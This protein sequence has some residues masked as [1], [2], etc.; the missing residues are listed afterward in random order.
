M[1]WVCLYIS[2]TKLL[3]YCL[4]V[5]FRNAVPVCIKRSL[6]ASINCSTGPPRIIVRV[7]S[8][9]RITCMSVS[10]TA[11]GCFYRVSCCGLTA[12][13]ARAGAVFGKY[14]MG[15]GLIA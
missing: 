4:L 1:V 9:T 2:Q 3:F 8:A 11:N 14:I 6:L 10:S 13:Y 12:C 7:I 15:V 5:P